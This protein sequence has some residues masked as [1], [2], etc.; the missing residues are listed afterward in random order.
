MSGK[1]VQGSISDTY[2]EYASMD[3][4]EASRQ[5]ADA[6]HGIRRLQQC[7]YEILFP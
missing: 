6:K 7:Q 5:N 2:T 1:A 4:V 3:F